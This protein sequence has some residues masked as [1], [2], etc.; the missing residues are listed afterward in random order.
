[1]VFEVATLNYN[2]HFIERTQRDFQ[3]KSTI[4]VLIKNVEDFQLKSTIAILIKNV[5]DFQ[6]KSTIAI[7]IKNVEDFQLLYDNTLFRTKL[8]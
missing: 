6:L 8:A 4:V 3:L 5:K 1:M 7:L 2:L